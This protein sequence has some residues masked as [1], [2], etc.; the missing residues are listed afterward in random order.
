[1]ARRVEGEAAGIYSAAQ[2]WVDAALRGGTFMNKLQRQLSDASPETIQLAAEILYVNFLIVYRGSI[3]TEKKREQI[4][5][6]LGWID[7]TI[8]IP[9]DLDRALDGGV[10]N[11]GPLFHT[12]RPAQLQLIGELAQRCKR[13]TAERREQALT[14]PWAFSD[15]V[16]LIEVPS[17]QLQG[18]AL[19]DSAA[20]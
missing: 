17:A 20:P 10:V 11:P 2:R 1:M 8:P 5:R 14:D 16:S 15:L 3:G 4:S 7:H 9:E 6:V 13:L 19:L 18:A 12:K